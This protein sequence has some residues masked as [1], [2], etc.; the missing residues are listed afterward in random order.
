MFLPASQWPAVQRA[1]KERK[2]VVAGPL[3]LV[4]GGLGIISR[5][6]IYITDEKVGSDNGKDFDLLAVVINMTSVLEA[7][8]LGNNDSSIQISIRGKDGFGAKGDIFYGSGDVFKQN[9]VFTS[10]MLPGGGTWQMAAIP[11]NG[12]AAH[13]PNIMSHLIFATA[14]GSVILFLLFIQQREMHHRKKI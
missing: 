8:G 11:A 14:V 2:T 7:V 4:Q 1:I 12:W 3:N 10:V 9:P 5:T 13:S 6:P